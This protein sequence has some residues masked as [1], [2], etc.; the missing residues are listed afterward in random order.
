MPLERAGAGEMAVAKTRRHDQVPHRSPEV[1][2]RFID[3]WRPKRPLSG[4]Q[5][6]FVRRI[7]K[8]CRPQSISEANSLLDTLTDLVLF[9]VESGVSVGPGS[10]PVRI[11]DDIKL[12]AWERDLRRRLSAGAITQGTFNTR[13]SR[14]KVSLLRL[15]EELEHGSFLMQR[16]HTQRGSRTPPMPDRDFDRWLQVADA[17]PDDLRLRFLVLLLASRGAGLASE[18]IRM[19]RGSE[20]L[21]RADGTTV[22][23]VH[24]R[25]ARVPVVLDRYADSLL[26]AASHFGDELVAGT[27]GRRVNPVGDLVDEVRGGHELPRPMPRALRRAYVIELMHTDT[28]ALVLQ[29]QLGGASLSELEGAIPYV[30]PSRLSTSNLGRGAPRTER[31]QD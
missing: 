5:L 13:M 7:A 30:D 11:F 24:G 21:R 31:E 6:A 16:G 4:D 19:L 17:Q 18:D 28:S 3:G 2:S 27:W 1:V 15:R 23:D 14:L 10:D 20:V 25:N 22:I 9:L 8:K 26:A 12:S 29:R